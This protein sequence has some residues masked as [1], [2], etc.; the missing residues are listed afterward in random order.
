MLSNTW[1][2]GS[3][4]FWRWCVTLRITK[5]LDCVHRPVIENTKFRKLD[6]FPLISPHTWGRKQ[7]QFPKRSVSYNRPMNTIPNPSNSESGNLFVMEVVV[8]F[9][10]LENGD[11]INWREN[12]WEYLQSSCKCQCSCH[13]A[14][15]P[16][17][18]RIVSSGILP[19]RICD[20]WEEIRW[21]FS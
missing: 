13:E 21:T 2:S 10:L 15:V 14:S 20:L 5:F 11:E 6:P 19:T 12:G 8:I 16:L 1:E 17:P 3:E 7:I 4:E 18:T 9:C